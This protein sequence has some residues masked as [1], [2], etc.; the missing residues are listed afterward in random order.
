M[1]TTSYSSPASNFTG[2]SDFK[3]PV[4]ASVIFFIMAF[5]LIGSLEL[6]LGSPNGFSVVKIIF[7][8]VFVGLMQYLSRSANQGW[9]AW[10]LLIVF[11]MSYFIIT[12]VSTAC[13]KNELD[14]LMEIRDLG[15]ISPFVLPKETLKL[16]RDDPDEDSSDDD[17]DY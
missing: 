12:I 7:A 5:L 4:D 8:L 16:L 1:A 6:Y 9:L 17:D 11:M 3:L 13:A 10:I 2:T 14:Q 15:L